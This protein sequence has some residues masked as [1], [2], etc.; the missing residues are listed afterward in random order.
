MPRVDSDKRVE[1]PK[2]HVE[3]FRSLFVTDSNTT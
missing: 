1:I 2:V 3:K